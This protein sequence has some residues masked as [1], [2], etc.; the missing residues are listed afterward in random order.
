MTLHRRQFVAA[1]AAACGTSLVTGA[2]AASQEKSAAPEKPG[3]TPHTKFAV[4]VEMWF[5]QLPFL[6]RIRRSA[7]LG[8]PAVEFWPY[9]NKDL[10]AVHD[11]T[12]ELG[13]EI[14]RSPLGVHPRL[15]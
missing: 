11:L 12:Q 3:K 8:F 1:T 13:I 9:D 14:S 7:E 5:T 10:P 4:N 2:A 6:D 15:E